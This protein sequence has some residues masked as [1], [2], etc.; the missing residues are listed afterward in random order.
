MGPLA[1]AR[2]AARGAGT[3]S[4]KLRGDAELVARRSR[5][6][7]SS[8]GADRE[9]RRLRS[10][11][12]AVLLDM[13]RVRE[14]FTVEAFGPVNTVMPYRDVD[15]AIALARRGEGSLVGSVFTADDA[16]ARELGAWPRAVPR[17]RAGREPTLREGIDRSRFAVAASGAW[18]S[19]SRRWR[20]GDGRHARRTALHA[21]HGRA[22]VAGTSSAR[23]PDAGSAAARS[24]IP[25]CTRS[26]S[27][28]HELTIGDTFNSAEREVT[29]RRTSS[30]SRAVGRSLLCAHGR[31][32]GARA[33]RSSAARRARLFPVLRR[34]RAC[35]SIPP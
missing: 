28:S 12:A 24:E 25:A 5:S 33:I 7:S 22:G 1:S 10:A 2:A 17:P 31:A 26:A 9:Q 3:A 35:S 11:D 23:S 32:R 14:R 30:A 13:P 19:G 34:P 6:T 29:R 21:A 20:R 27:P 18:R 8:A 16:V 15:E 4:R